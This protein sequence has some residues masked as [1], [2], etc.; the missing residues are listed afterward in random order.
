MPRS[1]PNA[2]LKTNYRSL[3]GKNETVNR[4]ETFRLAKN[5]HEPDLPMLFSSETTEGL[6]LTALMIFMPIKI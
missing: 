5:K 2:G 3:Q 6:K 1:F 4:L